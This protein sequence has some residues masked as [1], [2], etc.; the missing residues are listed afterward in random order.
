MVCG[1]R[2]TMGAKGGGGS[3]IEERERER[4]EGRFPLKSDAGR[5]GYG[6]LCTVAR[7]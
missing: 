5:D 7:G 6:E 1:K 2:I 3:G 4:D